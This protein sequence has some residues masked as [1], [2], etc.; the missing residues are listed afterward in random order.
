MPYI[1][2][3][4][5][6]FLSEASKILSSSLD[7]NVTISI[8]AKLVVSNIA[9]FCMVDVIEEG[10]IMKRL[11]VKDS[12]SKNQRLAQKMHEF[13]PDPN[14][15]MAIYDAARSGEPI[16][17][18][19]VTNKWLNSVS[20][21]KEE[22]DLVKQL[23]LISFVF[24]PLISRGKVIGVLTIASCKEGFEYS[25]DDAL[26]LKELANRIGIVVD[27]ARLYSEAQEAIKT[28]D[29]FL[30]IASHELRTPLTSILLNLQLML[31][32]MQKAEKSKLDTKEIVKLSENALKQSWRMS[33][34]INDLMNVSAAS[35]GRFEIEKE[36]TDLAEMVH[37]AIERFNNHAQMKRLKFLPPAEKIIGFWD[38]IRLEQVF[39]NLISNAMKYGD[40]KPIEV[41]I[42]NDKNNAYF[43]I[44]DK[45]IGIKQEDQKRIFERFERAASREYRGLGVGL[46][47]TNEIVKAHNGEIT[48]KSKEGHGSMFTISLP[49]K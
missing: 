27:K 30:S 9:D 36:E 33:R 26:F 6:V 48:L 20:K 24:A 4:K 21:I 8:V 25:Q 16:I 14:N 1:I 10:N 12:D 17:I 41:N 23:G 28:R 35:T 38:K 49:L 37:E 44:S 5:I 45:G 34:L 47:I 40:G 2:K 18:K 19:K 42:K 13:S 39:S 11:V 22:R 32:K 29:E 31:M 46:Y 3:D 15:K 43:I 7:Y